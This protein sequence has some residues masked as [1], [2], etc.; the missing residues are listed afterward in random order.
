MIP[1]I[2]LFFIQKGVILTKSQKISFFRKNFKSRQ[3]GYSTND[4][5]IAIIIIGI[6]ATLVIPNFAPAVEYLEVLIAEK[7]LLNSVKECQTDIINNKNNPQYYLSKEELSIGIFKK[8]KIEI[9]YTGIPGDC[10]NSRIA[11]KIKLSRVV[12]N[13]TIPKYSLIIN[14]VNG[15]RTTE[16]NLPDWLDW[17]DGAYSPLIPKYDPLI[18]EY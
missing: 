3:L 2:K 12:P 17:W 16:G 9:S 8:E 14:V 4:L 6:L 13:Q 15:E 5:I 1:L 10:I 18:E 7:Y 11:N